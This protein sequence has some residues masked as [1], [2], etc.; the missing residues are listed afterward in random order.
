MRTEA[1]GVPDSL[2]RQIACAYVELV[3]AFFSGDTATVVADS[4]ALIDRAMETNF[5][6]AAMSISADLALAQMYEGDTSGARATARQ[7][8]DIALRERCPTMIA[9]AHY[10]QGELDAEANPNSA[11]EHFEES[12]EAGMSGQNEFVA[13]ISLVAL[14]ATAGRRGQ[15]DVALTAMERCLA[16]WRSTGN[17]PQMWTAVRN[18]IELLHRLGR[19]SDAMTLHGAVSANAHEASKL[20]GPYG[21]QHLR[22]VGQIEES[23]GG[24]AEAAARRGKAL[25]YEAAA[26]FAMQAISEARAEISESR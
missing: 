25:S 4:P 2:E 22:I 19:D 18:L 8:M 16:Y 20:F 17:R 5:S 21:E 13:S 11:M 10:A 7:A 12:I 26:S 24:R 23:L 9:W 1:A 6:A 3:A 14:A 15:P